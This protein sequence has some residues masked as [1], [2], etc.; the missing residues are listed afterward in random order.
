MD[1]DNDHYLIIAKL[2]ERLSVAK[3][4]DQIVDKDRFDVTKLKDEEI[5]LVYQVQISN[6]FDALRTSENAGEVDINDTWENIRNNIK[7]ATGE[8]IGY[9]QVKKKKPWFDDESSN[10]WQ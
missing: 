9:Y 5:K 7:V 4:V 10:I 3:R 2:R 1:C 8:S 6:R